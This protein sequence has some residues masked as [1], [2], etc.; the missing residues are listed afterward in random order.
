MALKAGQLPS[1]GVT[2][3]D[4]VMIVQTASPG[5]SLGSPSGS[6]VPSAEAGSVNGCSR[7]PGQCLRC[8]G[9][10]G[11][12]GIER[13]SVGLGRSVVHAGRRRV[14]RGSSRSGEPGPASVGLSDLKCGNLGRTSITQQ[15]AS[16]FKRRASMTIV[17]FASLKGAPGVTTLAWLVGATWPEERKVMVVECDP[18]GGDLAARFRL[19]SRD[20]WAVVQCCRPP[21]GRNGRHRIPPAAASG[22]TRSPGRNQGTGCRARLTGAIL[23]FLSTILTSP[24][25]P[26]DVLVD[27]G[28]L[29]PR[30]LGSLVWIEH[31]DSVVICTRGDAASAVHVRDKVPAVQDRCRGRVGLEIVGKGPYSRSDIERFTGVPV[32]GECPFDEISASVAAGE[33]RRG[34]RL[35]RSPLVASTA[36]LAAFLTQGTFAGPD[37]LSLQGSELSWALG[38]D[39]EGVRS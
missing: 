35:G 8:R 26:W 29:V 7:A 14:H 20:G 12:H 2:S 38:D 11:E 19:S 5:A 3:G 32:F 6:G 22:R 34:R 28:R 39:R 4:Q 16:I 9:S 24:D 27:L 33:R 21:W 23:A 15:R 36:C 10:L 31:S 17:S 37:E 25:G 13:V 1:A 30:E 18:S